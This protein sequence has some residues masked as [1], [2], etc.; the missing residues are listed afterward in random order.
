MAVVLVLTYVRLYHGIDFTDESFYTVVSYRFALGARPL[1]DETNVA[2]LTSSVLLYPFVK[3]YTEA[4]GLTGLVLY[5]RHLY[6]I[7]CTG[8]GLALYAALRRC[9]RDGSMSAVLAAATVAFVPFSIY[10]L[11]YNTFART[12]FALGCFLGVAW[13]VDGR[14]LSLV[15]AGT[16][17]GLAV[18]TYPPFA[19]AV[20]C[21]FVAIY[22]EA[23][24]RSARTLVPG[25][26]A[27]ALCCLATLAFFLQAGIGTARELFSRA[28]TYSGQGGSIR[29]AFDVASSVMSTFPH[30]YLAAVLVA[31]ALGLRRWRPWAAI[32]PVV[33][34][35]LTA[36][37]TDFGTSASANVFVANLALLAP[38]VFLLT[39]RDLLAQRLMWV[40]WV[41]SAVA[42]EMTAFS[43]SNGSINF[44]IGSFPG[45]IVTAI[46][47]ALAIRGALPGGTPAFAE[48]ILVLGP[49]LTVLAVGVALQYSY[50]YRDA[51]LSHLTSRIETGAYAGLF[52]TSSKRGFLTQLD[53]DLQ[54]VSSPRCRILFYD[55]FPAGDLLGHGRVQTNTA[56]LLDVVGHRETP[57]RASPPHLLH[58]TA[59]ASG[60]RSPR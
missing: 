27:A 17:L 15:A 44:A 14:R 5:M 24:P 40:V 32:A 39:P 36:L 50:V 54:A 7:F 29:K 48:A 57:L 43:S 25:L 56:W 47:A 55:S 22:L 35:P 16:A 20:V 34:L 49:A 3:L 1:V 23:R 18:F 9:L 8:A 2:Q 53:R 41:P 6:F 37:P 31:A 26:V 38:A 11:S 59:G 46:L 45:A 42:G 4:A 60:H 33:A 52:T 58:E 12:F 30:P 28:S 51:G 19:P 10:A 13:L 21:F